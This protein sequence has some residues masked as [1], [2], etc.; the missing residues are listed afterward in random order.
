MG[1]LKNPMIT[2]DPLDIPKWAPK[3]DFFFVAESIKWLSQ[4]FLAEGKIRGYLKN[5]ID[6]P[7]FKEGDTSLPESYRITVAHSRKTLSVCVVRKP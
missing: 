5:A 6:T 7:T 4:H 3:D 2:S 1:H